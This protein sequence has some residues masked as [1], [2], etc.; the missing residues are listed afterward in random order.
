M[1]GRYYYLG[2]WQTDADGVY[3]PPPGTV[4]L[5]DLRPTVLQTDTY[6]FFATELPL[7]DLNYEPFGDVL[8]TLLDAL[9]LTATQRS[10]WASM[11]GLPSVAGPTL[12]DVLWETLTTAA[13]PDGET[14]AKPILPTHRGVL[15]L[16]LG[17]HSLVRSR[18]FTGPDDP[19]WPAIQRVLQNDYRRTPEPVRG[20]VLANW[21]AKYRNADVRAFIPAGL[22]V[23]EPV[24]P[25]TTITDDFDR[26][27]GAL[28][29]SAGGWAW[30]D[31]D[32]PFAIV[33]N[34]AQS[35]TEGGALTKN[36]E[37][38]EIDLSSDD[39][40]SQV[41]AFSVTTLAGVGASARIDSAA[42]TR[43]GV[44]M[45]SNVWVIDKWVAGASTNLAN[46]ATPTATTGTV[47]KAEANGSS[48]SLYKDG[49][50]VSTVTDTS[51]AGNLRAGICGKDGGK[52]NDFSA[53]DL[54]AGPSAFPG[55]YRRFVANRGAA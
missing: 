46:A 54:L 18:R 32:G 17:G 19:T 5:I 30:G 14:R 4:G 33:S 34:V 15:E 8:G 53:A 37:R 39:H 13:D 44:A 2:P 38:A 22:P 29:S 25:T 6:G 43:Y 9:T 16:H 21:M 31:V 24:K 1:A 27:D 40:E 52:L 10:R 28:G 48:I 55:Y 50:A 35:P 20:K 23:I 45:R 51:I 7:V 12:L 36:C 42:N 26:A 49:V 11:L 41:V 3:V 47:I